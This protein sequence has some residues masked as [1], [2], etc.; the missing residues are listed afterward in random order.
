MRIGDITH[1]VSQ[2]KLTYAVVN[3]R[4]YCVDFCIAELERRLDPAKFLRLHRST[5]VNIDWIHE[6]NSWFTGKL[7]LSLNDA[8]R[9]QIPVSRD[10]VRSLKLRLGI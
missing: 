3:G 4:R 5:L 6:A 10:R 7:I 2:D 8:P 9:T 1:F